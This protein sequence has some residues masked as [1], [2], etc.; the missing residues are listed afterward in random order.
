MIATTNVSNILWLGDR[1]CD[2]PARVGGKSAHLS[3][4]SADYQV[5]SGFCLTAAAFDPDH[6]ADAPL[7]TALA[8]AL[9]AAYEALARRVGCP[10]V[11]VA[12]RSS[13]L[14]ED[15]DLA[16]FAGQHETELNLVGV[17]DVL[18]AVV[19]CW[20][21]GRNERALA[22]RKQ[23][24]L[25]TEE[26]RLAVLVQQLVMVD[27]SAVVFS[28]NPISGNRDEVVVT[29]S[30]GLGE[31]VVSGTVTPDT[32]V[33][34][35]AD[36]AVKEERIGAKERMTVAVTGGTRE[37]TVPRLLRERA[38]LSR[39][40]VTELAT[41]AMELEVKMNRSVDIETAY[42][43][44]ELFLLQCRPITTL[45]EIGATPEADVSATVS[46]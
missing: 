46:D 13:A 33:V 39:A 26:V 12:V 6:S 11:P 17:D 15:G 23:Q 32:W 21:S 28:A 8:A 4:L 14:D 42:A 7:P 43:R 16:S 20:A 31:S 24:G 41:L 5:P 36:L 29:A 9:T 38:S 27:T 25:N 2:D 1:A 22:Y 45:D 35:K 19:R 34:R 40:Q 44:E 18:G 30:W 10:D 3:R 37:V